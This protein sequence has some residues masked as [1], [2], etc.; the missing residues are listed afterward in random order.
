VPST[1]D[2]IYA[3]LVPC[4]TVLLEQDGLASAIRLLDSLTL[5]EDEATV[6]LVE[7]LFAL[8]F[9]AGFNPVGQEFSVDISNPAGATDLL[10]R[11]SAVNL[12]GPP[13]LHPSAPVGVNLRIR[14][15]IQGKNTGVYRLRGI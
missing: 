5:Q 15:E 6:G 14:L 9:E 10:M 11:P 7:I 2:L 1:S 12:S 13:N 8:K 4:E 3:V